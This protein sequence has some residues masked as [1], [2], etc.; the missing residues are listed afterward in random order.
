MNVTMV[1]PKLTLGKS[2]EE[3]KPPALSRLYLVGKVSEL[4]ATP[5]WVEYALRVRF[6]FKELFGLSEDDLSRIGEEF[7]KN[8]KSFV[9][10]YVHQIA[11]MKAQ[12]ANLEILH[13]LDAKVKIM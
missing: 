12:Q 2:P 10:A 8:G 5:E 1:R 13:R 9:K 6:K 4:D 11:E 3:S 7:N